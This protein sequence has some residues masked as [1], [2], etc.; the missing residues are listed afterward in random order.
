MGMGMGMN[1]ANSTVFD[2]KNQTRTS[3]LQPTVNE[4]RGNSNSKDMTDG[5]QMYHASRESFQLKTIFDIEKL[6]HGSKDKERK[7]SKSDTREGFAQ[8]GEPFGLS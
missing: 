5:F 1:A 6:S 7:D 2:A 3:G 8:T 4:S